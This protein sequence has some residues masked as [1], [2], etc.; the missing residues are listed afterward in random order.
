MKFRT[1]I[2]II[3]MLV[4]VI[5]AS[6]LT[7]FALYITG[8]V[9]TERIE[10]V[11]AVL[12][13]EKVYDGT[14][15]V[16]EEY[17]LVSG[18]L[19][20]GHRAEVEFLGA[21]TDAGV[22]ES[23]LSV[24]IYD[25]KG[26]DVSGEY[27]IGV[28][29]GQLT[30]EKREIAV[31]LNDE[32]VVYNGEKVIFEN[33][34]VTKG[35]LVLGHK[36]GG[37]QNVQLINAYDVLPYDVNPVVFDAVGK[38][39]TNNYEITFTMGDIEV[40]PRAVT[41]KPLDHIKVYDGEEITNLDA[42]EIF[43]GSL[44]E[45][46]YFKDAQ[47]NFGTERPLDVCDITTRI[48]QLKIY[49]RI[50]SEEVDV[51]DN[52]ELDF[53]TETGILRI[54]PR[55]LTI[56]A[57]SGSWIYDGKSHD[58]SDETEAEAC[59][60]FVRGE[61]LKSVGYLGEITNVGT[62]K[63]TIDVSKVRFD[64]E[65]DG[66]NYE[67]VCIEGKLTVTQRPLTVVT[68]TF[69]K[70]FDGNP[71]YAYET[72]DDI[73]TDNLVEGHALVVP[74]GDDRFSIPDG[75]A[76]RANIFTV[77]IAFEGQDVTGNYKLTY[78]YG[79][80]QITPLK[81]V[82]KTGGDTW[83]YDGDP[84]GLDD[85]QTTVEGLPADG[86]LT[87]ALA[88]GQV[89]PKITNVNDSGDNAVLYALRYADSGA[90]VDKKNYTVD[91][92][93]GHLQITPFELE[94]TL[95]GLDWE[96]DGNAYAWEN[97]VAAAI[98]GNTFPTFFR[99]GANAFKLVPRKKAAAVNA[100]LYYY[101]AAFAD[102]YD[103]SN[104]LLSIEEDG[105][106]NIGKRPLSVT[107]SEYNAA[108]HAGE[109]EYT[110]RALQL[111]YTLVR[112]VGARPADVDLSDF[113]IVSE[114]GEMIDASSGLYYYTARLTDPIKAGNY[115][116]VI[117][118]GRGSVKIV[119]CDLTVT[120]IEPAQNAVY[121]GE[122]YHL[123][124]DDMKELVDFRCNDPELKQKIKDNPGDY[125]DLYTAE[126]L[127]DAKTYRYGISFIFRDV[128]QNF[129]LNGK[130]VTYIDNGTYV[131]DPLRATLTL[132]LTKEGD[133][134]RLTK[135]YNGTPLT[136]ALSQKVEKTGFNRTTADVYLSATG[137]ISFD[138][139]ISAT[140]ETASA[141]AN[142]YN[143]ALKEYHVF[144]AYGEEITRNIALTNANTE[145]VAVTI[146]RRNVTFTLKDYYVNSE[147]EIPSVLSPV[148]NYIVVST[149]TSLL[150]GYT[151]RFT[152]VTIIVRNRTCIVT[153]FDGFIFYNEK[154]EDV[155]GSFYITNRDAGT[156]TSSVI[157]SHS[158]N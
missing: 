113:E 134:A 56:T 107:L 62:A 19:Q 125:F 2:F 64:A 94:L 36:V 140:F 6:L 79:T 11:Y 12:D 66:A 98:G 74:E 22:S 25:R 29:S 43:S 157:V 138:Y 109:Y 72:A 149:L 63:S 127:R 37:S 38:D 48:T 10:L 23:S 34:T 70:E 75:V 130:K 85:D 82:V 57:K 67:I 20:E 124:W 110:G 152:E 69:N 52:Y 151:V 158:G 84:H 59:E 4:I 117:E 92:I 93:Y 27:K 96:Y 13:A 100:G 83:E 16:A 143:A 24:R 5:A 80:L 102:D 153:N 55:K 136:L 47:V 28:E 115:E 150:P 112:F 95:N 81:I 128:A 88:D 14:P 58:L 26:Y 137:G 123:T 111:N 122:V 126:T 121:T 41:V 148:E 114:S 54:E 108:T 142:A 18:E 147:S 120:F 21:Q 144:D 8:A 129:T 135:T 32:K 3:G 90:I 49:A 9:V 105:E 91:Y 7:V 145:T 77:T 156:L 141:L 131:I 97:F 39:V 17:E 139:T 99:D 44:A 73:E 154:G 60:G 33:Y 101:T 35:A 42:V 61:G 155:T 118:N 119:P 71:L 51:T 146:A 68:P 133:A 45:G 76:K 46:Q 1:S 106:L 87:A 31:T 78:Q 116:I 30:V 89:Y 50:G 132:N 53:W 103:G 86:N 104:F 40:L 65:T 15:L